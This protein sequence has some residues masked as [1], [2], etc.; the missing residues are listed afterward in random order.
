MREGWKKT[1]KMIAEIGEQQIETP[2]SPLA[3]RNPGSGDG[4]TP[5]QQRQMRVQAMFRR[6][7]KEVNIP[8]GILA[9]ALEMADG[10]ITGTDPHQVYAFNAAT[11]G[12]ERLHNLE[13]RALGVRDDEGEDDSQ[14]RTGATSVTVILQNGLTAEQRTIQ[15]RV[16][17]VVSKPEAERKKPGSMTADILT[18]RGQPEP[19]KEQEGVLVLTGGASF[20]PI[21]RLH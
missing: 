3:I 1:E 21:D 19:V 10:K 8:R 13:R 15:G 11:A 12:L 16:T 5:P 18:P 20:K 6:H 14:N 4:S 2:A 17:E 9:A 7:E